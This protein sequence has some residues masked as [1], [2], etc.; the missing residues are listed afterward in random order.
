MADVTLR[1]SGGIVDVGVEVRVK[2]GRATRQRVTMRGHTMPAWVNVLMVFS[3]I[4]FLIAGSNTSR[5][6]RVTLPFSRAAY[7]RW[8]MNRRCA[9]FAAVA[10]VG[11][12]VAALTIGQAYAGLLIGAAVALLLGAASLGA[13]NA[14]LNTVGIRLTRDGDLVLTGVHPAFVEALRSAESR[15]SDSPSRSPGVAR[16]PK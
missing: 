10:G 13:V 7:G 2:T 16:G 8:R 4:S 9:W 14:A 1:R 15:P 5:R 6:Y 3:F 12:L 11:A